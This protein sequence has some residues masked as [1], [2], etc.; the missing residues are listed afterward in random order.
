MKNPNLFKGW[1]HK[2]TIFHD[3]TTQY[4]F[5]CCQSGGGAMNKP[6]SR[7]KK[8]IPGASG[9]PKPATDSAPENTSGQDNPA[10]ATITVTAVEVKEL[11]EEEQSLRLHLEQRVERAFLEAGQAL[12]ELRV[13]P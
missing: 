10:L 8:V 6:P 11:T 3:D 7:R 2:N 13:R 1:G 4:L 12:M 9:E 5:G